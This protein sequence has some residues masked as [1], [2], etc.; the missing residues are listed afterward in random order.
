MCCGG[1]CCPLFLQSSTA[2]LA[3]AELNDRRTKTKQALL[4]GLRSTRHNGGTVRCTVPQFWISL[5]AQIIT[6]L[7]RCMLHDSVVP[8]K[9][10][11]GVRSCTTTHGYLVL[12]G[13]FPAL[14]RISFSVVLS[15]CLCLSHHSLVDFEVISHDYEKRHSLYFGV[16]YDDPVL[17]SHLFCTWLGRSTTPDAN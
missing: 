16:I 5:R 15:L 9:P 6:S 12:L 4:P 2:V 1:A 11:A 8:F 17:S 13:P 7:Q 14:P 10:S 3:T